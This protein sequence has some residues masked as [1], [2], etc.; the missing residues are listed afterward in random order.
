MLV[1]TCQSLCLASNRKAEDAYPHE[2]PATLKWQRP[3]TL[4][5]T[6]QTGAS[7]DSGCGFVERDGYVSV[8]VN[9]DLLGRNILGDAA[10]EP[11]IAIDPTDPRKMAIGWRQFDSVD[12]DFRQ[13]GVG[14]SHD[15]G[16]TWTFQGSLTPGVFGSDP[17]LDADAYG[18]FYYLSINFEEIRLFKSVDGAISW[19]K[20]IYTRDGFSDK[21][22]MVIDKGLNSP[23]RSQVY[24]HDDWTWFSYSTD[25]GHTFSELS[26]ILTFPTVLA[27]GPSGRVYFNRH[28]GNSFGVAR[29]STHPG[30]SVGFDFEQFFGPPM[31]LTMPSGQGAG[32]VNAHVWLAVDCSNS[33]TKGNV[34]EFTVAS[35][36][37]LDDGP[38]DQVVF[39]RSTDGGESWSQ[40]VRVNDDPRDS[41]VRHEIYRWFPTMSVAPNGRIDVIW[42]DG[43]ANPGPELT[44]LFYAFSTDAGETWSS[45]V[46]VS[47]VFG[48]FV[49]LPNGS[50]KLGDYYHMRSDNL[51][52]NVAYAATF[53]GEQDI[54]FLRI[55][56]HDCNANEIPDTTDIER[57]TSRDRNLNDI[58]D[59][60][61]LF[62]DFNGDSR[63]NL[64]DYQGIQLCIGA[65]NAYEPGP[66]CSRLDLNLNS[67]VN[68]DDFQ[69]LWTKLTP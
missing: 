16:N 12:S 20:P 34:Y 40:Y 4:P 63:L 26:E 25:G 45:N 7:V 22:W 65:S 30:D 66:R 46:A 17:V 56:P 18:N 61:E 38:S 39:G 33:P 68:L 52:V 21:P 37:E 64:R 59:E 51:G 23:G 62:G 9:V 50:K 43:R 41:P 27:V 11:S 29:T 48:S 13:A 57:G 8:Q 36:R 15:G 47:P 24:V 6:R 2:T 54:W 1:V 69:L 55:G 67:V 14:F 53:N 58:P 3:E 32:G 42:N 19:G 60:C 35:I 10:N 49:G 28:G 31:F 44:E 5:A